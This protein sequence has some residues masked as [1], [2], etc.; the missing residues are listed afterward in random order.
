MNKIILASHGDLSQGL[1]QTVS[2]IIGDEGNIFALSAFR[3]D[4]QPIKNQV[5]HLL[6]EIGY[7][8][9]FVLTDIFGGSVNNDLLTILQE[10]QEIHLFAGMNLPLVISIAT[11]SGKIKPDQLATI[12]EESRQG[13][14]DCKQ[15]LTTK[16]NIG[17][18]DL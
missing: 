7:D 18:D 5:E 14:I 11:Q 16:I 8:D 15:L 10:H 2:M 17:G 9:V 3:D 4:D 1:K 6:E 13:M 12:L